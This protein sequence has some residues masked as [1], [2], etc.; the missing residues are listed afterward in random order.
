MK[1]SV[2]WSKT[3]THINSGVLVI[4]LLTAL[5]QPASASILGAFVGAYVK[6]DTDVTVGLDKSTQDL[7]NRL[8]Q[9]IREQVIIGLQQAKPLID[10]SVYG[11]L[12]RTDQI[13]SNTLE[14]ARCKATGVI[15]VSWEEL[16]K[17]Y[18]T[19]VKVSYQTFEKIQKS[20]HKNDT[21]HEIVISYAD[22]SSFVK[23][24]QCK[25]PENSPPGDEINK[26]YQKVNK[27]YRIWSRLEEQCKF[28]FDCYS[29]LRQEVSVF[30]QESDPRDLKAG[31]VD[32]I[33][34]FNAIKPPINP[35]GGFLNKNPS[36]DIEKYNAALGE[37]FNIYDEVNLVKL[38]RLELETI[39]VKDQINKQVALTQSI[40]SDFN[41]RGGSK[42]SLI[43][44]RTK[45]TNKKQDIGKNI[46]TVDL[47][48]A[49][50]SLPESKSKLEE[51]KKGYAGNL[52]TIE[53]NLNTIKSQIRVFEILDSLPMFHNPGQI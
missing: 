38:R 29:E 35:P 50:S 12:D 1:K 6:V 37:L 47:L 36:I 7:I 21:P 26:I 34:R 14:D 27:N 41:N 23:R 31:Q 30:L 42:A 20:F 10:D 39:A 13:I 3:G 17:T 18:P 2:K 52:S 44:A 49:Q 43:A 16:I 9:N 25:A 15:P 5:S 45:L 40:A 53:L 8:P 24:K 28:P 19:D 4:G 33:N 22:L 11:Y 46:Q 51:V 48:V 32:A